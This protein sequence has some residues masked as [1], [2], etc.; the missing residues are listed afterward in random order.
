M[1]HLHAV[2]HKM[3]KDE[4]VKQNSQ[5]NSM[6]RVTKRPERMVRALQRKTVQKAKLERKIGWKNV[7]TAATRCATCE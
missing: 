3:E 7:Q 2:A 1:Q 4:G 6:Q 5:H